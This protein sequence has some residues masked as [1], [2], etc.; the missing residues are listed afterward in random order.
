MIITLITE[1]AK[2]GTVILPSLPVMLSTSEN[3]RTEV[4]TALGKQYQRLLQSAPLTAP[5]SSRPSLSEQ[6]SRAPKFGQAVQRLFQSS[7]ASTLSGRN[8]SNQAPRDRAPVPISRPSPRASSRPLPVAA[9]ASCPGPMVRDASGLLVCSTCQYRGA[10]NYS[11]QHSTLKT[12]DG[13]YIVGPA[14]IPWEIYLNYVSLC[15]ITGGSDYSCKLCPP[16]T[17]VC[18][19]NGFTKHVKLGH[20][21]ADFIRFWQDNNIKFL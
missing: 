12:Q 9:P 8:Q 10:G 19:I 17:G 18:G 14:I 16:G 1:S 11:A 4:V 7:P 15:P 3:T 2:D 20:T 21:L 5:V 6:V 13:N